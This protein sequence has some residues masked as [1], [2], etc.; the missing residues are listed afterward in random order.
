MARYSYVPGGPGQPLVQVPS[1]A[2]E[3]MV[4]PALAPAAAAAAGRTAAAGA[5]NEFLAGLINNLIAGVAI[6]GAQKVLFNPAGSAMG[7]STLQTETALGRS[8]YF[9]SPAQQLEAEKYLAGE[10]VKRALLGLIPGMGDVLPPVPT[11]EELV[12][13]FVDGQFVGQAALTEAQAQSLTAREIEK[14]RAEKEYDYAARLAEAQASIQREKIR[15]LSEA[16]GKVE[17]QKVQSLGEV[18][19]QRLQ[20]QYNAAQ[21]LLDSAIKNIAFRDRIESADTLTELARAV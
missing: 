16:Q 20:S 7:P 14:I 18:Q 12:G 21:N 4:A 6:E 8:N 1:Y 2:A 13:G 15:A 10:R 9:T 19:S 11:R 3:T 17:S 5:G